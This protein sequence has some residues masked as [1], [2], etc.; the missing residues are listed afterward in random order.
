MHDIVIR[1]FEAADA[2]AAAELF[3]ASVH[4]GTLE[5]YSQEERQ[6]WAARVPPTSEWRRRL[7]AQY[8]YMALEDKTLAGFMTLADD[9]HIDLAFVAPDYIGKGV[10]KRLYDVIEAKAR[11]IGVARLHA[12]ASHLARIFFAR[13]GWAEISRQEVM[14]NNIPLTNFIMEKPLN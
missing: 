8:T 2:K 6:A 7:A 13:Q 9:G 5:Y 10:A 1:P 12:E 4:L 11:E 3:Y 14:R